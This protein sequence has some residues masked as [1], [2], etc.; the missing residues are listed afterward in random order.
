MDNRLSQ[1][2][3]TETDLQNARTKGQLV[4]WVQGGLGTL[5]ALVV[6]QFVGWIPTLVVLAVIGFLAVKVLASRK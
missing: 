2:R 1:T 5:G 3:Y 6:L 4:G